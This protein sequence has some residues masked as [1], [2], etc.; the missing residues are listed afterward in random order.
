[1]KKLFIMLVLILA[2][3]VVSC[4][5]GGGKKYYESME[6]VEE[7]TEYQDVQVEEGITGIFSTKDLYVSHWKEINDEETLFYAPLSVKIEGATY[8][9]K[10][11]E[12][13]IYFIYNSVE[14]TSIIVSEQTLE[15]IFK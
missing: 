2:F 5:L 4:D 13:P 15:E 11:L 14:D 1:M 3:S 12:E 6:E 8:L 10:S 9:N 7:L